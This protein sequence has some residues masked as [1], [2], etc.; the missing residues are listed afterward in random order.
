M[1]KEEKYIMKIIK[2]FIELIKILGIVIIVESILYLLLGG[3]I[4]YM[5]EIFEIFIEPIKTVFYDPYANDPYAKKMTPI[6]LLAM[7]AS[8]FMESIIWRRL[9]MS[10]L[11][12]AW[13][14]LG[15]AIFAN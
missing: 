7:V 4:A 15:M 8:L 6:L 9:F 3:E 1:K 10:V 14:L 12:I 5:G 11:I 13:S 2:R